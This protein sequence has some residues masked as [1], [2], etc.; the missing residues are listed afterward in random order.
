[1]K[2]LVEFVRLFLFAS[3][4]VYSATDIGGNHGW[5]LGFHGPDQYASISSYL[6]ASEYW[7]KQ[8]ITG[9]FVLPHKVIYLSCVIQS[10]FSVR[11]ASILWFERPRYY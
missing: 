5:S 11:M 10:V 4:V 6:T 8:N 7:P 2:S 9:M 3:S 1:M